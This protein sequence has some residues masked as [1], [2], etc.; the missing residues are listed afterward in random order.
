MVKLMLENEK[1]DP[2]RELALSLQM[3][4]DGSV[5]LVGVD[6]QGR[7]WSLLK[8]N[9]DGTITRLRYV[10]EDIGMQV[11]GGVVALK[12]EWDAVRRGKSEW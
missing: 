5:I 2:R 9:E 3:K 4:D 10:R 7:K 6:D 1:K 12:E 8:I 11:D